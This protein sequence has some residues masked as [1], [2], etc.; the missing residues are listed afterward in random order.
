MIILLPLIPN[1]ERRDIAHIFDLEQR[2][3]PCI[4]KRYQQFAQKRIANATFS[5]AA[6]NGKIVKNLIVGAI[7]A[8]AFRAADKS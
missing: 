2:N 7:A 3:V 6:R 8:C 1:C 4:A 5:F